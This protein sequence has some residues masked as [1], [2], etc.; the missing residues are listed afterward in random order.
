M[1]NKTKNISTINQ[2]GSVDKI[3]TIFGVSAMFF[4]F[5]KKVFVIDFDSQINANYTAGVQFVLKNSLTTL[6]CND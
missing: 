5:C 6:Q 1:S 2:N 3:T 4:A